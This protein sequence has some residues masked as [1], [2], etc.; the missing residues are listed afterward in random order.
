MIDF[1]IKIKNGTDKDA[2]AI[3]VAYNKAFSGGRFVYSTGK[4]VARKG[5]NAVRATNNTFKD[6]IGKCKEAIKALE[7]EEIP[8]N[9]V[10][11][12]DRVDV[13]H[14]GLQWTDSD[15]QLYHKSEGFQ[16]YTIP[17]GVDQVTLE[18]QL[19]EALGKT[20]P[21]LNSIIDAAISGGTS[22]L[23][24]FW[25]GVLDGKIKPRNG[26]L[27]RAST[28]MSKRQT[29]RAVK[30][31]RPSASFDNMDRAFYNDLTNW[32]SVQ[33][34]QKQRK[35]KKPDGEV[36][37]ITETVK[38]FDDNTIGRHIKELKSI[39]HLASANELISDARFSYW[40]VTKLKNEVVPLSKEDLLK[41]VDLELSGTIADVRDIFVIACFS[42]ARISDF[43]KF[44]RQNISTEAG[45]TYLD[46]V[47]E[48]TGTS[49]R[50]PLHPVATRIIDKRDG[51]LP[52]M[53]SEQNFRSHVKEIAKKAKL[54]GRVVVKI[55]DGKPQY[56]EK[57]EA[58]S[59]HSARRT[60]ASSLFY[61]W[62]TRPMPA[63]MCMKFT[64]HA[65]EAS[66]LL[67][68]GADE[69]ALQQKALEYFDF[70]PQMKVS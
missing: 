45:I 55:R 61:G 70:Q 40:P 49:V 3:V 68:I 59:P 60:F 15:L 8:I 51:D 66:F 39:L 31:F 12:R 26:K 17:D 10:S 23:F 44:T 53:I 4:K 63:S 69:K 14:K 19:K 48:K 7:D 41:I 34:V 6:L 5:F 24:G 25:Q 62:F 22:E 20:K 18:R 65:T 52:Q 9:E 13:M 50:V 56:S 42:G 43:K 54:N 27:L 36:E 37:T 2:L 67:Y 64:G 1:S 38:R 21:N 16:R 58:I 35:V 57:W 47:A 46:Y 32:M 28:V 33:K 29:L 30:E 11:L